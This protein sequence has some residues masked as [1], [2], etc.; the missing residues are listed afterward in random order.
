[1]PLL[2][3]DSLSLELMALETRR[4]SKQEQDPVAQVW[5]ASVA[6]EYE[7]LMRHGK[8]HSPARLPSVRMTPEQYRMRAQECVLLTDEASPSHRSG[9]L[10]IARAWL[11]LADQAEHEASIMNGESVA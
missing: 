2:L 8:M 4:M 9:L 11:R 5:L 3:D 7:R 10:Q 6:N 1:M